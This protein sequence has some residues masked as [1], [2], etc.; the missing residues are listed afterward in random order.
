MP[1]TYAGTAHADV[2]GLD[3]SLLGLTVAGLG[4][5]HSQVVTNSAG[6]PDVRASS[7]NADIAVGG[8]PVPMG[9]LEATAPGD[10]GPKGGTLADIPLD[11]VLGVDAITSVV[12]ANYTDDLTCLPAVNGERLLGSAFTKVAGARLL[13]VAGLGSTLE[14]DASETTSTTRLVTQPGGGDAVVSRSQ[15]SVGAIRLLGNRVTVRVTDPVVLTA[16]SDGTTSPQVTYSDPLVTVTVGTSTPINVRPSSGRVAIPINLPGV[17]IS[18]GVR[19]FAP[20]VTSSGRT[21]SATLSAILGIDLTITGPLNVRLAT[22]NLGVGA[23]SVSATAPA[24]GVECPQP[25]GDGDGLTDQQEAQLGTDPA[26][27]DSD[28]DGLTDGQEVNDTG[29]DP[30]DPDSDDGG[31]KD[32]AE[33]A[34]GT[35]PN[36]GADDFPGDPDTDNDGLTDSEEA[37]AGTLPNNPDTDGDGLLDGQEVNDTDTDPL[38]PDSDDGGVKDGA[39]IAN[40]TDPN[41]GADDFPGDPD[42]D[43]DGLTDSEEA[44]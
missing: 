6:S 41:N 2:L 17:S 30:L 13:G 4:I 31:V 37:T 3:A 19:A 40:G 33:I 7:A 12:S 26:D 5:G 1:A 42:T 35:D 38:D 43:N 23:S 44:T 21:A 11:P 24:G 32:G 9:R 20:T 28:D 10:P 8:T 29:T 39:E 18:L 36:N 15:T 34:N 14:A 25:D 27:P 22:V 16:R